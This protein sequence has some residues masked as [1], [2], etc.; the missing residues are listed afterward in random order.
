MKYCSYPQG[1]SLQSLVAPRSIASVAL[2]R[3]ARW[4]SAAGLA[5]HAAEFGVAVAAGVAASSIALI[6]F[7]LDSLVE[8]AAGGVV[9][10][11]FTAGRVDSELAER[12]AQR[13]IALSFFVLTGYVVV[14][15]LRALLGGRH[16]QPSL[17]GMSLAILTIPA[18]QVLAWAKRRVGRRL[19][20]R[21][22]VSESAQNLLCAYLAA[23]LLAGL[24]L[25][26]L[27]GWWWADPA[28]A[29]AIAGVALREGLEAW[30][31]DPCCEVSA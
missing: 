14:Q 11:R 6:A 24:G 20:S 17:V 9:L 7:G 30:R 23:G 25:N 28:A 1:V 8:A 31:G 19:G 29:L 15:A 5:W 27:F 26:A 4:L 18:M 3:R 12:R 22:A 16:P 10:W 2:I 13:M 21:A